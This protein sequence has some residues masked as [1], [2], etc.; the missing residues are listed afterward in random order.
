MGKIIASLIALLIIVVIAGGLSLL[1]GF[2][3][4]LL[5]NWLMPVIFGLPVIGFWQSVGMFFL[6]SILFRTPQYTKS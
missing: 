1:V 2:P 4:M 6:S 5:W 3:L